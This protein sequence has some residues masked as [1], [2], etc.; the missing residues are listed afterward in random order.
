MLD[1]FTQLHGPEYGKPG[2]GWTRLKWLTGWTYQDMADPQRAIPDE[3][4]RETD[5]D[6]LRLLG[7]GMLGQ[8]G[9][10]METRK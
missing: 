9:K 3:T 7:S 10:A 5:Q 1:K 4:E 8:C 2:A 6:M